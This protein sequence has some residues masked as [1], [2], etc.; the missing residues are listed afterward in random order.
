MELFSLF[1]PIL[2]L[3][4]DY[5]FKDPQNFPHPV[6]VV[7]LLADKLE[8]PARRFAGRGQVCLPGIGE[9]QA[10]YLSGALCLLIILVICGGTVFLILKIPI[11]KIFFAMYFAYAG[12]ALGS[13][14]REGNKAIVILNNGCLEEGRQAVAM[15]VS[16]DL[17]QADMDSLWRALAESLSENFTDAL[18]APFFWLLLGG[19]VGLW[20]YKAVSTMDSLWG[21]RTD[22][23]RYLG[24]ASA[25][26]DDVMAFI[27]ARIAVFLLGLF[28]K[29]CPCDGSW[30]GLAVIRQDAAQMDSP[31]AGWS[32][33]AAAWLH[34][35]NMGGATMYFGEFK[36]KPV[37]GAQHGTDQAGED[38]LV[39]WNGA[40]VKALL[41]HI[42]LAG[43]GGCVLMWV[44]WLLILAIL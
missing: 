23:W 17:S 21:Y 2:A 31:N 34:A 30:P 18:I 42:R 6:Q 4:F 7:A 5:I 25:R 3:I 1:L 13:L 27:P 39:P 29:F 15:L 16:R 10:G 44:V 26:L 43:L 28:S 12:L 19:P 20:V 11:L 24:W 35:A 8:V 14:L 40:K 22:K 36:Q 9:M 33:S 37:L 41:N 38:V 32:M